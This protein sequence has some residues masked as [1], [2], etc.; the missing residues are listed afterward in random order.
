MATTHALAG[1][2]LVSVT[3]L[4]APEYLPVAVTAAAAGGIFPD[5]DLSAN[6]RRTLHFPVLYSLGAAPLVVLAV[7]APAAVTVA[8]GAF[9]SSAALHSVMDAFGGGLEVKPWKGT[10]ERAVYDHYRSHWV[11]PRRWIR[12]DGAPEDVLFAAVLAAPLFVLFTGRLQMAVIVLLG[13]SLVYGFLR[14]PLV[15]V[16]EYLVATLPASV[17][18]RIP[19]QFTEDLSP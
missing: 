18:K 1:M 16:A 7:L 12:Y 6:H 11:R 9:V 8:V 2:L 3:G 5:L 4:I 19:G 13:S 17:V 10:S 15:A 14:K